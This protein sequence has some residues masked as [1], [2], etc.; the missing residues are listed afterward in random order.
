MKKE[1]REKLSNL[2]KEDVLSLM[3][4]SLFKLK[5]NPEYATI[6]E[7]AYL[8]QGKSFYNLMEYYGGQTI[9]VPTLREFNV[10]LQ[11]LLLY[12][13][14][15]LEGIEYNQALKILDLTYCTVKEIKECYSK[16]VDILND[17]EFN[18]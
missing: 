17:Y 12:Q 1:T 6:S 16:L 2:K 13:Y 8:L 4:F 10:V 11:S 15:N 18:R 3:M 14:V 5:D 7:L 9:K